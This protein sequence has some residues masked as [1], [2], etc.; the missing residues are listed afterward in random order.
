MIWILTPE[1]SW[2]SFPLI[3]VPP[4]FAHWCTLT[5]YFGESIVLLLSAKQITEVG[6]FLLISARS[7]PKC[8]LTKCE[9]N[10]FTPTLAFCCSLAK[11]DWQLPV[12]SD[13]L[14]L[15]AEWGASGVARVKCHLELDVNWWERHLLCILSQMIL[16]GFNTYLLLLLLLLVFFHQVKPH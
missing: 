6:Y 4:L 16:K 11:H 12:C 14:P 7:V 2:C 8:A 13:I 10:V 3:V 9:Q 1:Q 15:P 5:V